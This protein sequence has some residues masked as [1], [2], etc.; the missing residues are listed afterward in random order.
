MLQEASVLP[1]PATLT[2]NL[3]GSFDARCPYEFRDRHLR[4]PYPPDLRSEVVYHTAGVRLE[5]FRGDSLRKRTRDRSTDDPRGGNSGRTA[6]AIH[7]ELE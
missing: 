2:P 6:G 4:A 1:D 7:S 5:P 3:A